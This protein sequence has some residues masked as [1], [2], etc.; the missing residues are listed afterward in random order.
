MPE[1]R[2]ST[3]L[4]TVSVCK[5]YD[6]TIALD[7]IS[8]SLRTGEVTAIVG[9]NGSGKSTLLNILAGKTSLDSGKVILKGENVRFRRPSD[10]MKAGIVMV[11]QEDTICPDLT[12]AENI[13]LGCESDYPFSPWTTFLWGK[14]SR[15]RAARALQSV[16]QHELPLGRMGYE[17]SGGQ[18]KTVAIARALRWA[19]SVLLLDEATNSLGVVEQDALLKTVKQ[20]ALGG[21]CVCY[22][23]HRPLEALR[24]ADRLVAL[25]NGRVTS[26]SLRN[27]LNELHVAQLM[28]GMI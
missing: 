5:S 23:T 18:R 16:S 22:V 15:L 20:L 3:I 21:M 24:V 10:A 27:E 8:L 2:S 17:L 28:A 26:M 1:Q 12:V 7:S 6:G 25:N 4:E 19:P 13:L 11:H 14:K 9:A